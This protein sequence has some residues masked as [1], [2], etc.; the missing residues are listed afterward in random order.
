VRVAPQRAFGPI[1]R[2]WLRDR[3]PPDMAIV[4]PHAEPFYSGDGRLGVLVLHG[5]TGSPRS[6]RPWGEHLAGDGFRVALPRL[7]GHG[8]T[9]QD[10]DTTTWAD[11]YGTAEAEFTTLTAACDQ[12][13]IAALSVG[14]SLAIRLAE[15]HGER[16]AGLSLVNPIVSQRDIRLRLL[17]WLRR[18]LPSFPGVINDIAKPGQD[19]GGYVRLPLNALYSLVLVGPQLRADL[20]KVTSPLLIFKSNVDHVVD[21]TSLPLIMSEVSSKDLTVVKLERSYHVATMDYDA[22]EIFT[23]TSAFFS[24]LTKDRDVAR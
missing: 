1:A 8:T 12:V 22:D 3:R 13:F 23:R 5:F 16:V 4:R 14:S 6:V 11:W 10:L 20:P 15:E 21:T 24:G 19:E 17:P 9:W 2:P 18:L 7:P